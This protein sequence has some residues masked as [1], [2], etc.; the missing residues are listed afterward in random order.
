MTG[1]TKMEGGVEVVGLIPLGSRVVS[2][3]EERVAERGD[4]DE[5]DLGHASP[6]P[7]G[8]HP[9]GKRGAGMCAMVTRGSPGAACRVGGPR[10]RRVQESW[11]HRGWA[12]PVGRAADP[13]DERNLGPGRGQA[14]VDRRAAEAEPNFLP[15]PSVLRNLR[16]RVAEAS[17]VARS[18]PLPRSRVETAERVGAPPRERHPGQSMIRSRGAALWRSGAPERRGAAPVISGRVFWVRTSRGACSTAGIP[19]EC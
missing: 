19:S 6:D 2:Q 15:K 8:R 13:S 5:H 18:I 11:A 10:M 16:H 1:A 4:D 12:V 9:M 7:L 17:S 14:G 3:H